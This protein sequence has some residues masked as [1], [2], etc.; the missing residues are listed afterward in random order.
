MAA[1]TDLVNKLIHNLGNAFWPSLLALIGT[2]AV[3]SCRGLYSLLLHKFALE[4]DRFAVDTLIPR[5]RVPSL[6]EQYQE[7]KATLANVTESLLQREGRFHTAVEQL[8]NLVSGISPA[9]SGLD[10]AAS[11]SKEAAEKL[12]SRA[13][14]ITEGLNRHL[15][16]KSPI[17]RAISGFESIFD[18]AD[19]SLGNLSFL[20]EGIGKSNASSQRELETFI[21]ALTHSVGRIAEDH[22]SHQTEAKTT[23]REFKDSMDSISEVIQITSGKAVDA[24]M[25][26]VRSSVEQLHDEQNKWHGRFC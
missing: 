14:S 5:Y 17:H 19:V 16:E 2:I 9:L 6:S 10:A 18:K 23:L 13:E 21:Q 15:G 1:N 11:S 8:E 26:A 20:V 25:K 24:G 4:L 12:A 7:V 3:V 22:Q